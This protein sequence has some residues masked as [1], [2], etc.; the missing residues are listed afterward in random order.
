MA[1]WYLRKI[2]LVAAVGVEIEVIDGVFLAFGPQA[3]TGNVAANRRQNV[4]AD[5]AQQGLK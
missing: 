4:K 3:F 5:A 1:F 2:A